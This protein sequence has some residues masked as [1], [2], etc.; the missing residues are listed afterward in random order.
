MLKGLIHKP[1]KQRVRDMKSPLL[2]LAVT[3]FALSA[4]AHN[5][6]LTSESGARVYFPVKQVDRYGAQIMIDGGQMPLAELPLLIEKFDSVEKANGQ[7][8]SA[9]PGQSDPMQII[10]IVPKNAPDRY[11][12]EFLTQIKSTLSARFPNSRYEVQESFVDLDEDAKALLEARASLRALTASGALSPEQLALAE[13]ADREIESGLASDQALC[14]SWFNKM[15]PRFFRHFN[16]KLQR[17]NHPYNTIIAAHAVALTKF[18]ISA[19]V[20]LSK[21]GVNVSSVGIAAVQGAITAAFGFNAKAWSQ[22]CTAHEFPFF[23]ESFPVQFYN[24]HGWLKSAN[25]NLM[26]SLGISYIMRMLAYWSGQT[27]NGKPVE[28]ANSLDFFIQGLGITLPEIVLDGMVDDALRSLEL[29]GHIRDSDRNYLIWG[30]SF[31]DTAMHTFFRTGNVEAAYTASVFSWAAKLAVLLAAKALKAKEN[32][33]FIVSD[34]VRDVPVNPPVNL[35]T[36]GLAGIGNF[37]SYLFGGGVYLEWQNRVSQKFSV[38]DLALFKKHFGLTELVTPAGLP[39]E[40]LRRLRTDPDLSKEDLRN[41]LE[42]RDLDPKI[43]D[44]IYSYRLRRL[45]DGKVLEP[46]E[47]CAAGL[48][49]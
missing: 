42:L 47:M 19:S 18:G 16:R 34:L 11:R 14:E 25:I 46:M 28:T 27:A 1:K 44:A 12:R 20:T 4:A 13:Q 31:I 35:R 7:I 41:I 6:V 48:V 43:L 8:V 39:Q 3:F 40:T 17:A 22:W 36:G 38:S 21:Y 32:R 30:I 37:L 49:Q 15:C 2:L 33:L 23:K 5:E 26:R 29:G 9:L 45:K 24:R 10:V